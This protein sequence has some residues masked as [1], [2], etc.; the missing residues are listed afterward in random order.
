[1]T[2]KLLTKHHFEFRSLKGDCTGSS[3]STL[4]K[5]PHCWKSHVRT[6]LFF[7]F[8]YWC[9]FSAI[10][11]PGYYSKDGLSPFTA[12]PKNFYTLVDASQECTACPSNRI[13]TNTGSTSISDCKSLT[14]LGDSKDSV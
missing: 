7:I 1:M 10:A 6:L 4:V 5:I 14:D 12:C 8:V 11:P 9:V 2:F 13:T 3:V